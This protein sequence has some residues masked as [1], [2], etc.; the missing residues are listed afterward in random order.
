MLTGKRFKLNAATV[1]IG[2]VD[3]KHVAAVVPAGSVI[4]VASGPTHGDRMV[5]VYGRVAWS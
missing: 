5:D 1:A 4:K 3:G 2:T